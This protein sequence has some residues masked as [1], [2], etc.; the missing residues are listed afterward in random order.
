MRSIKVTLAM[1]VVSLLMTGSLSAQVKKKSQSTSREDRIRTLEKR[2]E[3]I[4]RALAKEHTA[5]LPFAGA[6]LAD[7]RSDYFKVFEENIKQQR[8]K[9][10]AL[11]K[12]HGKDH[13]KVKQAQ[14]A[15]AE[16]ERQAAQM[17]GAMS[18]RVPGISGPDVGFSN[19]RMMGEYLRMMSSQQ[20]S[21]LLRGAEL[22][23][24]AQLGQQMVVAGLEVQLKE[25]AI[26]IRS[27]DDKDRKEKMTSEL[28]KLAELIVES[29]SR[30]RQQRIGRLEKQLD[31]LRKE[32]NNAETSRQLVERLL[33]ESKSKKGARPK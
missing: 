24:P 27:T 3:E 1:I 31:Q 8:N 13:P 23:D 33:K 28:A 9:L 4:Q 5:P 19:I 6:P 11:V 32:T 18:G 30:Y 21:M 16:L 12:L 17:K 2:L 14:H 22:S 20:G 15:L 25:I 10:E 26:R 7:P 29:R